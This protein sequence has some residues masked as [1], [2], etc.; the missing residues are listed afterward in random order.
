[1]GVCA[2]D[3]SNSI[4][5]NIYKPT[6]SGQIIGGGD[7]CFGKNSGVLELQGYNGKVLD[8][9]Q[10]D[11]SGAWNPIGFD[12]DL[13]WYEKLEKS[14]AYRAMVQNGTCEAKYSA[15]QSIMIHPMPEVGFT[16]INLCED[17][18]ASFTSTT[19]VSA[20]SIKDL[21]W[22]F[23]DGFTT[24]EAAFD[25]VFQLPGK[26]NVTLTALTDMGCVETITKD[27]A[28]GETPKAF[29]RINNGISP[30]TGCKDASVQFED[31]TN[32][33]SP[34]DLDYAWDFDN[35]QVASI[36]NPDMLFTQ[37]G[38][39]NVKLT[40]TTRSNCIDSYTADYLVLDEIKPRV[41]EDIKASLGIVIQLHAIG[42]IS[43]LWSPAEFLS[44][45][46]IASPMATVTENTLFVVTGTDYY[47]CES[48]DSVWVNVVEDYRIIPNNVITPDGNQ[49][50][51]V[52]V[53]QNLEN[54]PNNQVT[55]FDRWGRE[56]YSQEGYS[57][58]WGAT[59]YNGHLLMD[60]TYY[61]VVE[62]PEI[63]KVL[64]GAITVVR[65]K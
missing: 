31:L 15:S 46:N 37:S 65:N 9:E 19:Q 57:N 7:V 55:V 58:D 29:F 6:I 49:E 28:I 53:I 43:Y 18:L 48:K 11:E 12:G 14:T 38:N 27:I 22:V 39:Y 1:S 13:Y 61:Y 33:S 16:S 4:L 34:T 2:S 35:E 42:N 32:F 26:F 30:Q 47:G 59:N 62:F 36:T 25:K 56:V 21:N 24:S 60:G 63:G 40:V 50:N 5:H 17:Q 3:N 8:W 52:W 23:S 64:K 45:A 54:Y 20:G 41:G 51:D 44:D 10:Q